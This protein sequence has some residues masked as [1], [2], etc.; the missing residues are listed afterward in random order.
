M[1]AYVLVHV[2]GGEA[3]G[4]AR[5]LRGAP[6]V[7]RSDYVFGTYDVIVEVEGKDV[8]T[9]GRLVFENIR[10]LPGVIDTQTCLAIE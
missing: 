8:A 10:V 9:I 7:V 4:I 2:R 1:R 5:E 6:G 3:A